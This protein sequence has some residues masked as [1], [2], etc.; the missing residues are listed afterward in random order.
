MHLIVGCGHNALKQHL[1]EG[2]AHANDGLLTVGAVDDQ[3]ADHGIVE[4]RNLVA[5]I[6][7]GIHA[8]AG[9]ARQMQGHQRARTGRKVSRRIL[10]VDA[11][12]D[13]VTA[14]GQILLLKGQRLAC[15][16][17]KLLADQINAGDLLG[18]RVLDLNAGVHLAEVE[19]A[20]V[21]DQEFDR[22]RVAVADALC[23]RN[24]RRGH[25]LAQLGRDESRRTFLDQLLVAALH[26]A[27]TLEQV[28]HIAVVIAQNLHL[29]MARIVNIFFHV[30]AAVAEVG[31][32]LC[33]GAVVRVLEVLDAL[34]HADALAAAAG[35]RLE[36]DRIADALSLGDGFVKIAQRTVRA[37]RDRNAC[38]D[39]VALCL[40]FVAHQADGCRSRADKRQTGL[41]DALGKIRILGQ[42][43]EARMNG[44]TAGSQRR[45]NDIIHIQVAVRRTGRTDAD[46]FVRDLR[47]QRFAVSLGVNGHRDNA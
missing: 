5:L 31:D 7:R 33:S 30:Q 47:V 22:T 36:H 12:L 29:D 42:E 26:R 3:L 43:A 28:H 44:L 13:G 25:L 23:Q 37:E 16:H 21:I 41:R 39:R 27:L 40:G 38:G 10:R 6:S 35:G 15:R 32:S 14:D 17:A 9:T 1:R 2:T 20:V 19:I 8:H 46:R 34:R 11:A 24:S 45:R 4:R 18:D